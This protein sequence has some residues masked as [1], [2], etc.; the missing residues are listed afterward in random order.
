[1]LGYC[2]AG[3]RESLT[4][5]V[6]GGV[7]QGPRAQSGSVKDCLLCLGS[8]LQPSSLSYPPH[9]PLSFFHS[10]TGWSICSKSQVNLILCWPVCY[11]VPVFWAWAHEKWQC[12]SFREFVTV[13]SRGAGEKMKGSQRNPV[14]SSYRCS[15]VARSDSKISAK[16]LYGK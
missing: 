6:E 14:S 4:L 11:I 9:P 13:T 7:G 3:M 2:H 1:M 5:Y 8:W 10:L 15:G 16:A 12:W